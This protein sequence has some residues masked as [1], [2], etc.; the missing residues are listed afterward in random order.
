VVNMSLDSRVMRNYVE[1]Y[2][3]ETVFYNGRI[4]EIGFGN[5][6]LYVTVIRFI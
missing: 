1:A 4:F 2:F 6:I 3:S 5:W